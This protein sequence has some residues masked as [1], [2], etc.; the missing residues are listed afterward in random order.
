MEEERVADLRFLEVAVDDPGDRHG[1][2]PLAIFVAD[3]RKPAAMDEGELPAL[4]QDAAV[5]R[6]KASAA[7]RAVC[8]HLADRQLPGERLALRFEIDARR[9]ALELAASRLAR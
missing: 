1:G 6:R 8:D 7:L 5:G 9:K 2:L 3:V 4:E